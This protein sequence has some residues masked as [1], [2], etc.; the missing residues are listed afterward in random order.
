MSGSLVVLGQGLVMLLDRGSV[1]LAV[2]QAVCLLGFLVFLGHIL[3]WVCSAADGLIKLLLILALPLNE[4]EKRTWSVLVPDGP[5]EVASR[6]GPGAPIGGAGG[7]K[8]NGDG[9][10][11]FL[12]G[13]G[14]GAVVGTRAGGD[15]RGAGGG[16]AGGGDAGGGVAGGGDAGGG[17]AGGGE[18]GGGVAGGGEAGG[19]VAGGGDAGG[20]VAG[21]GA[22]TGGGVTGGG[23]DTGGGVDAGGGEVV[24][25]GGAE[26]GGG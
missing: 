14:A 3:I 2:V 21:G 10:F 13:P 23:E 5:G 26:T 19:G 17:V 6:L 22:E 12:L 16:V 7:L 11:A 25:G 4:L 8:P 9:A 15:A 18:A 24:T 20:G 1:T